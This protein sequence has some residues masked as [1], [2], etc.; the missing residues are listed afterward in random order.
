MIATCKIPK[1]IKR[2]NKSLPDAAIPP[3]E[4]NEKLLIGDY[5]ELGLYL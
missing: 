3:W 2:K 5:S 1:Y 4:V